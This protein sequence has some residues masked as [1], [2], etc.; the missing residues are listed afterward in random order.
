MGVFVSAGSGVGETVGKG[1]LV[2]VEGKAVE[3]AGFCMGLT[4]GTDLG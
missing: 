1:G 2:G 4:G 3:V